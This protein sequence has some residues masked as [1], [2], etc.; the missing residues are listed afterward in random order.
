MEYTL[1]YRSYFVVFVLLLT[2]QIGV[3]QTKS[4]ID[5]E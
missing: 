3:A 5:S 1:K 4:K 2:F